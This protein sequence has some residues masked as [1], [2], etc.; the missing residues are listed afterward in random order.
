MAREQGQRVQE[1]ARR[2]VRDGYNKR[3]DNEP[4]KMEKQPQSKEE[5]Q[6]SQK[7]KK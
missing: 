6:T 3:G 5:E 1:G 7:P 2:R 4:Q